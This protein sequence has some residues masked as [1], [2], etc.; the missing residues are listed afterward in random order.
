MSSALVAQGIEHGSPKAG[1]AGSNPAGGTVQGRY[2]AT[3]SSA[4]HRLFIVYG[5]VQHVRDSGV[6]TTP[7]HVLVLRHRDPGMPQVVGADPRG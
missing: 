1:V 6:D 3:L 4:I 5:A 2:V 7:G